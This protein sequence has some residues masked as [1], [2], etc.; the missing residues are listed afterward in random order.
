MG[1]FGADVGIGDR[2][3]ALGED[4]GIETTR[5]LLRRDPNVRVLVV[6]MREDDESVV[7]SMRVGARGYLLK[8]AD[9][10]DIV[11]AVM[12]VAIEQQGALFAQQAGNEREQLCDA[13]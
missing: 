12:S 8:G 1:K 4:S 13:R 2:E 5:E 6:T 7:A 10:D 3:R 9:R 11:R